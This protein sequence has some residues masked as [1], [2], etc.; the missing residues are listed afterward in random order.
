[1]SKSGTT[2]KPARIA[3]KPSPIGRNSVSAKVKPIIARKNAS[4]TTS[5]AE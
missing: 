3:L 2:I 4:R 1:V 5:P